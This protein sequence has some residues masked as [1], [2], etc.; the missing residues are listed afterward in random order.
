MKRYLLA[1]TFLSVVPLNNPCAAQ[2][3]DSARI[4]AALTR[5]W[6]TISHEYSTIYGLEDEE[7]KQYI[8]QRVCIGRDSM[9]MF[10]GTLY[11]PKF[12][13][14]KVNAEEY[15]KSNFDCSKQKLDIFADSVFEVTISSLSKPPGN[16]AAHKMTDI[17]AFDE[18]CIYVVVDGVIFKMF[19]ADKKI[20]GRSSN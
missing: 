13:F 7:V 5:C 20:E 14:R 16:Q 9:N 12:S 6:R 17:I 2:G 19:D 10:T 8:K 15:S 1:L 3:V 4:V 18:D 11:A